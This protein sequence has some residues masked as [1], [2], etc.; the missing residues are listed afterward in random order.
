MMVWSGDWNIEKV[1]KPA[2]DDDGTNPKRGACLMAAS[3]SVAI[4]MAEEKKQESPV[5]PQAVDNALVHPT[6]AAAA[7]DA[8][9]VAKSAGV[10]EANGSS[11]KKKTDP[12]MWKVCEM[13]GGQCPLSSDVPLPRGISL[14]CGPPFLFLL[15][16]GACI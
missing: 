8:S 13:M 10:S 1:R 9:T 4:E 2:A 12:F 7:V 16:S 6:P 3:S 15:G 11:K 14:Y 5:S